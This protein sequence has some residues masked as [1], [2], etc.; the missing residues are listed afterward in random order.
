MYSLSKTQQD[1]KKVHSPVQSLTS[2][3]PWKGQL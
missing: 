1:K 2:C 3:D